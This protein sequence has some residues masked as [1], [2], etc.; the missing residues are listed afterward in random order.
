M[1]S[2]DKRQKIH[3]RPSVSKR[4]KEMKFTIGEKVLYPM[5]GAGVI[6]AVEEHEVLGKTQEYYVLRLLIDGMRVMVP[7]NSSK[8]IGLRVVIDKGKVAKVIDILKTGKTGIISDWKTRYNTNLEKM[9]T[10]SI[11]KVAE[12]VRSLSWRNREK[13]LSSG[14]QKLFDNAC[15][16]V[17]GELSYAQDKTLKQTNTILEKILERPLDFSR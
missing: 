8:K 6:D 13:G 3:N 9:K 2:L 16:L 5:H 11:Y 17:A 12:V 4:R 14:E 15:Q 1:K 10:G 7:V